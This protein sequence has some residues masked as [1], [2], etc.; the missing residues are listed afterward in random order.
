[1][2]EAEKWE[3]MM[4]SIRK[5][6]RRLRRE[7]PTIDYLNWGVGA[8]EHKAIWA[9]VKSIGGHNALLCTT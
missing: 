1:M 2:D 8:A 6:A 3:A 9:K 7:P 5:A 4:R